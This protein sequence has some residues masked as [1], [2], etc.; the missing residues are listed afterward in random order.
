MKIPFRLEAIAN[1]ISPGSRIADI[2][3]DHGYLPIYLLKKGVVDFAVC[4]DVKKG[5]LANAEKNIKKYG[6]SDKTRLCLADGL[7]GINPGEADT[8]VIAG[9]G[10]EMIAL[11]LGA[12]VPEGMDKFVL[13]P[14]RNIDILRKKL[15]ALDIEITD[16]KIVKEKEKFYIIICARKGSPKPWAEEEYAVSPFLKKEELWQEFSGREKT[17]LKRNL[18]ELEKGDDDKKKIEIEKLIKLYE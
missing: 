17:K 4:S 11:I 9:M 2:G 16:E 14:M 13:Q 1:L 15:H 6:L 8:A 7:A 5:P 3:T 10:G 12:G 18:A